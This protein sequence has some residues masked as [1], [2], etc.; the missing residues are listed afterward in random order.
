MRNWGQR[1]FSAKR[2][3]FA[4]F[5]FIDKLWVKEWQSNSLVKKKILNHVV[6]NTDCPF[7]WPT[8]FIFL[9]HHNWDTLLNLVILCLL[10]KVPK[11]ALLSLELKACKGLPG[12]QQHIIW[13]GAPWVTQENLQ[14]IM[15]KSLIRCPVMTSY[16]SNLL[17]FPPLKASHSCSMA[18]NEAFLKTLRLKVLSRS[19]LMIKQFK[20]QHMHSV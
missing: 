12:K 16:G 8:C 14:R 17:G 4:R 9:L 19:T 10:K 5:I 18:T 1:E 11:T 3:I 20:L 2:L 13:F 7:I 15:N 6:I